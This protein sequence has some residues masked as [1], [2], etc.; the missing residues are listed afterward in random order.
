MRKKLKRNGYWFSETCLRTDN[1]FY[2]CLVSGLASAKGGIVIKNPFFMANGV[3]GEGLPPPL[4]A[5][6]AHLPN[7][8]NNNNGSSSNL[9][10]NGGPKGFAAFN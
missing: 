7:N 9:L 10:N 3:Q 1:N 2:R 8:N 4:E 6:K 5:V